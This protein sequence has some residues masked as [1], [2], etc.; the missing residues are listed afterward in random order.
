MGKVAQVLELLSLSA[1][2][3]VPSYRERLF[4]T[5]ENVVLQDIRYREDG[6]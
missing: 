4:Y 1:V 3:E 6:H 5:A 2:K